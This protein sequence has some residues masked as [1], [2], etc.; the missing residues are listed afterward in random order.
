MSHSLVPYYPHLVSVQPS[1]LPLP[2]GRPLVLLIQID[3]HIPTEL[4]TT[5]SAL[6]FPAMVAP[7]PE[8]VHRA[9]APLRH[10]T[11]ELDAARARNELAIIS[12]PPNPY[13]MYPGILNYPQHTLP[14]CIFQKKS[15]LLRL[16]VEPMHF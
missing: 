5:P 14:M 8:G 2:T 15:Q 6:C 11:G 10:A 1:I 13:I 16:N 3:D 7:T 12:Q 9:L 4:S